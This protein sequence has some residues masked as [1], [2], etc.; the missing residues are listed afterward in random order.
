[1]VSE[2]SGGFD[3]FRIILVILY[4]LTFAVIVYFSVDGFNYY[5]TDLSERPHHADYRNLKPG[6]LRGHGFGMIGAAMLIILLSYSL[7]KRWKIFRTSGNMRHW[8]NFHI[9]LGISGPILII[10]HSTLKLNGLVSVSFW[11]MIA[12]AVSGVLGR[13]LYVQIPRTMEGNE[14]TIEEV[15]AQ[16]E[17]L[18][19]KIQSDYKLDDKVNDETN[20]LIS[21]ISKSP[22]FAATIRQIIYP[23]FFHSRKLKSALRRTKNLS[24]HESKTLL[25]L[26]R[27]KYLLGRRLAFWH[28][29]HELFHYWHVIHKPFAI[30]MYVIMLVHI[31][32][33]IWLGYSWIF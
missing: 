27:Q 4:I 26:L 21:N 2:I 16:L 5:T 13:Y 8:L 33:S 9:Y 25:S 6:G 28:I 14:L 29:I 24:Q 18:S 19:N 11:A 15:K 17:N 7:R 20:Q 22:G 32:I 10:L 23:D 30:I 3:I 31:G 12:V 1:M